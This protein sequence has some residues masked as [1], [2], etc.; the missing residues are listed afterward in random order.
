M[1][2][3]MQTRPNF[4]EIIGAARRIDP[5]SDLNSTTKID[6]HVGS[7]MR[8]RRQKLSL[9]QGALGRYL[10]LTFSQVQKYENGTNR[11]GAGRLFHIAALLEVP[12]QYF[13]EGLEGQESGL[14]MKNQPVA[15]ADAARLREAFGRIS[16]PRARQALLA[17]ATSLA[18]ES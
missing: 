3:K 15:A 8:A 6:V 1:E 14:E 13:F 9:S 4:S 10:G 11:I 12:V 17:L 2:W 18:N 5:P 16:D 7:R